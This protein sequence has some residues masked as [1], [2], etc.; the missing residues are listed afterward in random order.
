MGKSLILTEKPS[1]GRE[2]ARVLNCNQKGA[3]CFM[4]SKY[5]VTWAL[6]HLVTL[7]DP[8]V[9][10]Q[11]Y[12]TWQAEDLP[13]L[14]A[15]MELV[16]IKETAKQFGLVRNLLKMPDID[17]LIIA[18]DAGREGELVA[19][20]IIA[21]VGF[22]KPIKRLWI[23]SQTDRA[24]K[25]GFNNLRPG[26]EYERL[27]ASAECRAEA[28]W[29]VGLN[30]TRALTCKFNAQLSAGRV[31]T[32]TLAMVV[33]REEEI[34]KFV[35]K[36]F[37][38]VLA[39]TT[40]F[41]LQWRDQTGQT[42]IFDKGKADQ[43]VTK[44]SGQT[45]EVLEVAKEAKKEPPPLAYDL[46]ELQRDANRKYGFSAK[47]TSAV[48]Q[49]LYE[50]HKLVTYPRTDSRYLSEDIV[51]TLP[52]R[53]KSIAA[54]PYGEMA[55]N[56]LKNKIV[57]T[58]RLVDN[59]KV[60]DHHA[61]IPT[62][63]PVYLSKL[64]PE[65]LKVYDLIVKRFIAI[66]SPSFEYEQTTV[67]VSIQGE[68]F[69]ARGKIVK[70]KGWRAVYGGIGNLEDEAEDELEEQEQTLPEIK[71]GD[72]L[73]ILSVKSISGKTKPPARYTEAT[74]LSAME[75]PGK[76]ITNQALR[77]AMDNSSGLGTP[78]TRAEIIEKLFNSFYMERNGKEIHP[79]SKGIQLIGLVPPELKSP[80][81][82]AKWERELTEISK[83]RANSANFIGNIKN[84]ATQLVKTVIG[85]NQTYRH[86]NLTRTKCPECGKF[87]L[88]VKGKRGEMY[89][90][91]D[92]ECG[93]RQGISQTSNA[94]CPDCHK[95]MEIRGEGENKIFT[96]AC[97]YREKL[98]AFIKRRE[99]EKDS[100]NKREV[101][102]FLQQQQESAPLNTALADALSKLKKK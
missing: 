88:Q 54:G 95:K 21:K 57:T 38:T 58:K 71:K 53:L 69:T 36:D 55:R 83:G 90:C 48:M 63:E 50:N 9:Y 60:T 75:H 10:D 19:R 80:E 42:R 16:V 47:A 24:I 2:I 26:N 74:L 4:G 56:I 22:R 49:Q 7:A 29:L 61:I 99:G 12:K 25:E 51:S 39:A 44:V 33:A 76:W 45:G 17:E 65:E 59:S 66:L 100:G 14:P 6:G 82:T 70:S 78:A 97:G 46:T 102:R 64:N 20:W 37:W 11:K 68:T 52:E 31:Q 15:K 30:V 62:E 40:G 28:D 84:Y 8:E 73:K 91:Q 13:M 18:T 23:S 85:S 79:T 35:P 41:S 77:E 67:K 101:S 98:S 81:L 32:P 5:I 43:I 34:K 72:Q 27:Y 96:C 3:G 89:V 86:D 1:V 94:R 93:Y 92:R 87:L